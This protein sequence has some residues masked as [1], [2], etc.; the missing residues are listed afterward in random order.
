MHYEKAVEFQAENITFQK[1]LADFY[2]AE[3]GRV[4]D[5]LAVYVRV[6]EYQPEDVEVLLIAGHICVALQK[7]EDA[8]DF[9]Q[10]V[11]EI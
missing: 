8:K 3:L 11:L 5:A 9:Y 2:Y 1:N 7:F 10:R 4:E 6:L